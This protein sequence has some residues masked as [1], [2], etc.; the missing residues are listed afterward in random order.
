[1]GTVTDRDSM[2][3]TQ[4]E[5]A[6][7][8]RGVLAFVHCGGSWSGTYV[9]ARQAGQQ[10]TLT[11]Q[12]SEHHV[13]SRGDDGDVIL[14]GV[15]V[16]CHPRPAPPRAQDHQPLPA[17]TAARVVNAAVLGWEREGL[18]RQQ[19]GSQAAAACLPVVSGMGAPAN[20]SSGAVLVWRRQ[21]AVLPRPAHCCCDQ[22]P[23]TSPSACAC[24]RKRSNSCR[25]R[26]IAA[27][28]PWLGVWTGM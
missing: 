23:S 6:S 20:L 9:G 8:G 7:G 10:H 5:A 22:A 24:S 14:G 27:A 17:T 13:V 18:C 3:P 19:A 11:Q 21:A 12:G 1:M 4:V 25:L 28:W 15:D 2:V 16:P 26:C